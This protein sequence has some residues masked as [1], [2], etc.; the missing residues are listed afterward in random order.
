MKILPVLIARRTV[1]DENGEKKVSKKK[2]SY[3]YY[4]KVDDNKERVCK[5]FFLGTLAISQKMV[6]NVHSKKS[7]ETGIPKPDGKGKFVSSKPKVS[8]QQ[9][10]AVICH[11]RSFPT[12]DSHY[13][14]AKTNKKIP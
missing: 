14:R 6:Y 4:L 9:K 2:S 13:Y 3:S 5:D 10:E 1:C 11:I 12:I 7:V 8:L